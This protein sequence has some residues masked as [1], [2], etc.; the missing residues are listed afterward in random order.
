VI[1]GG[2]AKRSAARPPAA[3]RYREPM[4][5]CNECGHVDD[6]YDIVMHCLVE[7]H[8]PGW[9]YNLWMSRGF[10]PSCHTAL[11]HLMEDGVVSRV[12]EE[13]E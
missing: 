2:K 3:R 4:Y 11:E 8:E 1:Y 5:R 13:N 12:N 6:D 7:H 9:V 10:I